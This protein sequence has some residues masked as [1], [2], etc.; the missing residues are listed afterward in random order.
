MTED[1]PRRNTVRI[2]LINNEDKLLLMCADDPTTTTKDGKYHGRFWFTIGG[3]IEDGESVID[4]AT[5]ELKE[6]T[7]LDSQDV[8]FG[9][10]VWFGEFD[11]VYAGTLT[12][13]NEQFIVVHTKESEL[14]MK[15]LTSAE[16][17]VIKKIDW[18]SL[19]DIKQSKEVIFPVDLE[20]LLPDILEKNYPEAP[21]WIDLGKEPSEKS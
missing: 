2:L 6:E 15:N 4:A 1:L 8:S 9:L 3:K 13:I 12:T 14:T 19:D 21:I 18:F 10:K 11:L 20:H 5:R 16:K 17:R 7:G